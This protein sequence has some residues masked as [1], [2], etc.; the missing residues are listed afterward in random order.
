MVANPAHEQWT[1]LIA[2]TET[3]RANEQEVLNAQHRSAVITFHELKEAWQRDLVSSSAKFR[4]RRR[5]VGRKLALT[6]A[7][8]FSFVFLGVAAAWSF[9][10]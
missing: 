3:L 7:L 10:G 4:R 5:D 2:A 8:S 6:G 9:V 1:R